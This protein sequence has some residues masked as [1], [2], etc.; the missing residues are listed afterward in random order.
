MTRVEWGQTRGGKGGGID[1][2]QVQR[3][4]VF[5]S[6]LAD[7]RDLVGIQQPAKSSEFIFSKKKRACNSKR[8]QPAL[9]PEIDRFEVTISNV[10]TAVED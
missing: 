4:Q 8:L 5:E 7:A 2:Q 10:L 3:V 6:V 1:S 9:A